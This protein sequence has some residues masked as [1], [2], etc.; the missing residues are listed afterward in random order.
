MIRAIMKPRKQRIIVDVDTQKHFFLDNGPLC[1]RDHEVVLANIQRIMAWAHAMHVRVVS[2][3]QVC[4]NNTIYCNSYT[5]GG[6]SVRKLNCTLCPKRIRFDAADCT[7]VPRGL[8]QRYDQVI[9]QKRSFD[10]F[11]EPRADRVLTDLEADEFILVG[12]P[13]E[14]AVKATA[15]GL[16]ARGKKVAVAADAT[17]ALNNTAARRALR[18]IRTKGARCITTEALLGRR[19]LAAASPAG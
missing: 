13:I 14:G 19:C 7:D 4:T 1:V 3:V 2:T 5:L 10:P 17:G 16:L 18:K 15:L 11:D 12:T 9:L 6:L 8:L